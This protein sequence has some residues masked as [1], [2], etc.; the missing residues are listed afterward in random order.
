MRGDGERGGVIS[1]VIEPV[2]RMNIKGRDRKSI[3]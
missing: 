1:W 2:G 3:Q